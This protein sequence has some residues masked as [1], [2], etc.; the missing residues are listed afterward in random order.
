MSKRPKETTEELG[1]VFIE[2]A[3]RGYWHLSWSSQH[4]AEYGSAQ[5][6]GVHLGLVGTSV[7]VFQDE[8]NG[9][10]FPEVDGGFWRIS[11][12][13]AAAVTVG[14]LRTKSG[15]FTLANQQEAINPS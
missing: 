5:F 13:L 15:H 9:I 14:S 1:D 2:E 11:N 10:H 7:A 3:Y 6:I 12:L 4:T 8:I